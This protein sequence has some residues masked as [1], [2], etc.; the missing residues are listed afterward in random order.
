MKYGVYVLLYFDLEVKIVENDW[1][2]GFIFLVKE[3]CDDGWIDDGFVCIWDVSELKKF[4][5]L[6]LIFEN[7]IFE[8]LCFSF[9]FL[10]CECIVEIVL[11]IGCFKLLKWL[12]VGFGLDMLF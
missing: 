4:C 11:D 2:W 10:F 6:L 9:W 7:G 12:L 5:M 3:V 1:C 8:E